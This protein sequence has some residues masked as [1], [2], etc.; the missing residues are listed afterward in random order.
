M[1]NDQEERFYLLLDMTSLDRLAKE[2]ETKHSR[3][4]NIK[5]RK[6]RMGAYEAGFLMSLYPQYSLWIGTG[7]VSP[8]I[9]QTSPAY[10]EANLKLPEPKTG[11][12]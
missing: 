4:D 8:E 6:I 1:S 12:R 7:A 5:R 9:G 10:D 2:S 11:S 3:W